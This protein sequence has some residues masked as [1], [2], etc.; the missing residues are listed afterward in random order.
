[1]ERPRDHEEI[2]IALAEM[3]PAPRAEFAAE[4]DERVATG[5][6]RR[7]R[8]G[9][10]SGLLDRLPSVAPRRIALAGGAAGLLAIAV[11]TT[12]IASRDSGPGTPTVAHDRIQ[13]PAPPRHARHTESIP[14]YSESI[15]ESALGSA[16][17]SAGGAASGTSTR[18]ESPATGTRN[19]LASAGVA[20]RDVERAAE[21]RLLAAPGDVG[22]DSARVFAAVHD[23][24]G[25]VLRSTTTQGRDAGADF[26]LL[27]P[28][29]RL[30][31]ALAAF[32]AID[33][34]RAR[35]EATTD[36]T[37]PT[38]S[39][40]EELRETQ[41]AVNGL[42]A[43]LP[44][45]GSE[46]EAEAIEAELSR[47]R[48]RAER[49]RGSLSRLKDRASFSHVAVRIESDPS[50]SA[51]GAWGIGDAFHDA[52]RILAIAAGVT[53]IGLAVLAPIALLALLAWLARR[54]WLQRARNRALT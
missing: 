19:G 51:G 27:I 41:A 20:H 8:S 15:P 28:S 5:F 16:P 48:H 42:L 9:R 45:A 47:H 32:S 29:A 54:A 17:S 39:V 50:A 53:L 49:L 13:A 21:V 52:G 37:K 7:S 6:A 35:H 24:H 46:A 3:R 10:L 1:M 34:V 23:A 33:D 44:E 38:V 4:L 25:I 43:R 14:Q 22:S 40:E 30:G 2:G 11:A 18:V 31:D 12:L 26:D 36:I